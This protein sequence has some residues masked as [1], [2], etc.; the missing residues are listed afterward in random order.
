MITYKKLSPY[1]LPVILVLSLLFIF[2]GCK[3]TESMETELNASLMAKNNDLKILQNRNGELVSDVKVLTAQK[4]DLKKYSD[5]LFNLTKK[6]S[7]KI[8]TVYSVTQVDQEA[9]IREKF[10]PYAVHDTV[11]I[12]SLPPD[13]VKVPQPFYYQD[14]VFAVEGTVKKDGVMIDS[15]KVFNSV[16]L[17]ITEQKK[18]F[19][20]LKRETRA[21]VKNTNPAIITT[22]LTNFE[23]KPK[24][25]FFQKWY[26]PIITAG[27]G[28]LI[29][30]LIKN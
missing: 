23:V 6:D 3:H 13:L 27:T 7:R 15:M 29:R 11:K 21:Q 22:G 10:L 2:R 30:T 1:L 4:M 25:T 14:S 28:F 20:G 17:R 18:G 19:L 9:T 8:K 5:S 24:K 12:D 16:Y 26:A